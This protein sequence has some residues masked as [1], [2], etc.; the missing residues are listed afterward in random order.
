MGHLEEVQKG[1]EIKLGDFLAKNS[2][3]THIKDEEAF[4]AQDLP[5]ILYVNDSHLVENRVSKGNMWSMFGDLGLVEVGEMSGVSSP[6]GYAGTEGSTFPVHMK[7]S[8]LGSINHL[9]DG[10]PKKWFVVHPNN[11][12]EFANGLRKLLL[13]E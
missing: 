12:D 10:K 3:I 1:E 7:D 6:W 4:G 13:K 11:R 5:G 2:G 9:M 8:N